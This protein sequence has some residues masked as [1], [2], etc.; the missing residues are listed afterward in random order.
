MKM[1]F[2]PI[3]VSK[4]LKILNKLLFRYR[5]GQLEEIFN[6]KSGLIYLVILLIA[7]KIA[8]MVFGT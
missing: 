8:D 6:V 7:M 5:K 1:F 4:L 3:S 2:N